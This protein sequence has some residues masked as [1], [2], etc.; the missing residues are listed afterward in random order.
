MY[1]YVHVCLCVYMYMHMHTYM[2][3]Y[4][5]IFVHKLPHVYI[6]IY[7]YTYFQSIC[8]PFPGM[9]EEGVGS[10][11]TLGTQ[12]VQTPCSS[13]SRFQTSK[14]TWLLS[15]N[16][17]VLMYLNPLGL[18]QMLKGMGQGQ[19]HSIPWTAS[20]PAWPCSSSL[21]PLRRDRRLSLAP[22]TTAPHRTTP[23]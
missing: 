18:S 11:A 7:T 6:Y 5:Y 4:V 16:S 23:P 12:K 19:E 13:I 1:V 3:V 20:R 15:F 10:F 8:T 21:R 14:P 2:Y 9:E 22:W 17:I